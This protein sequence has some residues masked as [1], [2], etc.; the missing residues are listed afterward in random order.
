MQQV[1]WKKNNKTNRAVLLALGLIML[2]GQGFSGYLKLVCKNQN[3]GF[4]VVCSNNNVPLPTT[5][6]Y[7]HYKKGREEEKRKTDLVELHYDG[8]LFL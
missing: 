6:I 1:K 4:T 7:S 5:H 2:Y 8:E 3:K